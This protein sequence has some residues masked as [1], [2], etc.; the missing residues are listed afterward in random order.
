MTQASEVLNAAGATATNW[1]IH[2]PVCCPSR[3]EFLTGRYAVTSSSS[4]FVGL[5]DYLTVGCVF[6]RQLSEFPHIV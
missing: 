1:F 2:T 5:F 3:A 6:A 4:P